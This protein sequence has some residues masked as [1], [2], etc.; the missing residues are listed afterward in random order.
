MTS[1]QFRPG[2]KGE[3][4]VA[5]VVAIGFLLVL[6]IL[7]AVVLTVA[8]RGLKDVASFSPTKRSFYTV[9]QAVEY[10][11]NGDLVY[12]LSMAGTISL[13]NPASTAT[14]SDDA[15][16]YLAR[17][18]NGVSLGVSHEQVIEK[19]S[20]GNLVSGQVTDLGPQSLPAS[21]AGKYTTDFGANLYHVTAEG[22]A[23]TG[24]E[25]QKVDAS[26]VRLYKLEDDVIFRTTGGG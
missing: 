6:S 15:L 3:R 4:G 24:G 7:G 25:T 14:T 11:M 16:D 21:L 20:G 5:L 23:P 10:S 19:S 2:R 13:V 9:D 8:N 17:D 18:R 26:I 12:N 1:E 22:R